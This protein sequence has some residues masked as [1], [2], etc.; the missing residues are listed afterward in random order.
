MP[1]HTIE[2][3]TDGDGNVRF[4]DTVR[5]PA[6]TKVFVIIPEQT[7]SYAEIVPK[8]HD[9]AS[10]TIRFPLVRIHEDGLAKRLVKTIIDDSHADL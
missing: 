10:S 9:V 4:A 8:P 6:H 3:M 2:A 5:L 1:V 7:L